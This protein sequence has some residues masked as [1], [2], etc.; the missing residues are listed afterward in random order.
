MALL[1]LAL[2]QVV[3]VALTIHWRQRCDELVTV[4]SCVKDFS[5]MGLLWG[6]L[7]DP[8]VKDPPMR[9]TQ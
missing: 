4:I 2:R 6:I 8:I 9:Y 1:M 5:V 7:S 3:L